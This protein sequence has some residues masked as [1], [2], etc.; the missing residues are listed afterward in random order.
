MKAI[1]TCLEVGLFGLA[2]FNCGDD[3]STK[4]E[5]DGGEVNANNNADTGNDTEVNTRAKTDANTDNNT[6]ADNGTYTDAN[7]G[8]DTEEDSDEYIDADT[9]SYTDVDTDTDTVN[10]YEWHTFFGSDSRDHAFDMA[11]DSNNDIYIA[12]KSSKTWKGPGDESPLNEFHGVTNISI[13]KLDSKGSY[14]WHTFLHDEFDAFGMAI[15]SNNDIYIAGESTETWNGPGDESPLNAFS[16]DGITS[17]RDI[18]IY[19]LDSNG[20][21][22]WHIFVGSDGM[23]SVR[24]IAIDSN[25]DIYITGDSTASW[26][27]PDDEIALNAFNIEKRGFIRPAEVLHF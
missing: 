3:N 13:I 2:L 20:S 17:N 12:G 14:M 27:G 23:D 8:N 24:D 16:G 6:Q 5:G 15:D 7:T 26:N 1:M 11:I 4:L 25:N 22:K 9:D 21:Y 10:V 18:V 19:K